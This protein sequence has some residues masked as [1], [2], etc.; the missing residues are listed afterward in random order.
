MI[1]RI[2]TI[3]CLLGL[4][5]SSFATSQPDSTTVRTSLVQ[6][7]VLD[8]QRIRR[9]GSGFVISEDRLLTVAHLVENE[10]QVVVVPL[11][12][13]AELLARTIQSDKRAGIALLAVNGLGLPP[14]KF[15]IDGYAPGRRVFTAGVWSQPDVPG[16]NAQPNEDLA[17][18][19]GSVGA[20]GEIPATN[21]AASVPL[22]E[23]NA[24]IP[25]A[26]YG[27][28]LLNECG[29]VIGINR[30][31]PGVVA[32]RLRRGE[33][34][35]GVVHALH[36]T[37]IAEWLQHNATGFVQSEEGCASALT[38]AQEEIE[39]ATAQAEE[40]S[41]Q[42]EAAAAEI[43]ETL[44]ALEQTQREKD[45]ATARLSQAESRVG[46]L[47]AQYEEAV[48]AGDQRAETLGEELD[49][50]RAEREAASSAT[51]A[52]EAQVAA[53]DEQLTREALADRN[54]LM[55]TVGIVL[56]VFAMA[57]FVAFF[58]FRR[59]SRQLAAAREEA[60]VA[61]EA[62]ADAR[63]RPLAQPTAFPDC[64]LSGET[65][66]GH[67]VSVK[68]PGAMLVGDG[69]II[70]RSPRNST[71]LID[72]RTLSREHARLFGEKDTIYLEDL[73]ATN[74]TRVNG[75][76]LTV[77][78]PAAVARGDSLEFAAV[79]VRLLLED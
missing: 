38:R 36:V 44:Q 48:R 71:L 31:T 11:T 46:E 12:S 34:P 27:G 37:A 13:G 50:A 23:H 26:G 74:G 54:R 73:G 25:A 4:A 79:K 49:T 76:K 18:V 63:E 72:D 40:A 19:S 64:V 1:G 67:P 68:V 77:G 39:E 52:L 57:L 32:W 42:A 2:T 43:A 24:M 15:G 70:G 45:Q 47:E 30:G 33:A 78:K 7:A 21:G 10:D 16:E 14:L 22:I 62:A 55:L 41:G 6:V 69:A 9:L 53:L 5:A 51:V 8:G 28:P 20:H 59:R 65:G 66:D 35:S 61:R 60:A 58:G 3:V 75:R 17:L 29:E 56:A